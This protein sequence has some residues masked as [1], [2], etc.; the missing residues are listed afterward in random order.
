MFKAIEKFFHNNRLQS[1]GSAVGIATGYGLED[2]GAGVRFP[3][4]QKIFT[5]PYRVTALEPTQRPIQWVPGALFPEIKRPEREA[6]QSPP[7]STEYI[8]FYIH[9]SNTCS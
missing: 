2:R 9:S 6:D 3:V 5:F 4:E 8:D 7:T 1:N